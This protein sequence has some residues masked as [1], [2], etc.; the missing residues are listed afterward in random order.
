MAE[1][2]EHLLQCIRTQEKVKVRLTSPSLEQMRAMAEAIRRN[3]VLKHLNLEHSSFS[4]GASEKMK[5]LAE[6]L[7]E[8]SVVKLGLRRMSL[9]DRS[10]IALAS[11]LK[12]T[13]IQ[14]LDLGHNFVVSGAEHLAQGL[15]SSSV[16][17]LDLFNNGIEDSGVM[18][19]A[20]ALKETSVQ[21]LNLGR[22]DFGRAGLQA[23][24]AILKET[25]VATLGVYDNGDSE[26]ELEDDDAEALLQGLRD[27]PVIE[28]L[29]LERLEVDDKMRSKIQA[30]LEANKLNKARSF[31]LQMEVQMS[32]EKEIK[33]KFRTMGGS[34]AAALSWSL[35]YAVQDLPKAVLRSM[36]S[37]GFQ[38][39]F[40][41]L[42]AVNLKLVCPAGAI[43]D[44]GP[45]AA[46]LAQQL[47]L[48]AES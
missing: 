3:P 7:R 34:E 38:P 19:L 11:V 26:S 48:S 15:K 9:G 10:V 42:S 32:E 28:M 44:V 36:R 2:F 45:T 16:T 25:S 41:G 17:S 35:D 46:P 33:F 21:W 1:A 27:S 31:L 37:S 39:P 5:V 47:G 18:A 29:K 4:P 12:E 24:A 43:L 8:S 23:L 30:V 13:S 22:N 20:G 40:R 14:S 6:G